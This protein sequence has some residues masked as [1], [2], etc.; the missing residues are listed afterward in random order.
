MTHVVKTKPGYT[1]QYL[2]PDNEIW[3]E[4]A[5]ATKVII[6]PNF[7]KNNKDARKKFIIDECKFHWLHPLISEKFATKFNNVVINQDKDKDDLASKQLIWIIEAAKQR[8]I[9]AVW[10]EFNELD[11]IAE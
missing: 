3:K 4:K 6:R 5:M 8:Y 11:K 2:M 10:K 1:L 7:V 9:E